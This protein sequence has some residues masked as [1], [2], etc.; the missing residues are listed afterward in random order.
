[1]L[2]LT[3]IVAKPRVATEYDG[4]ADR[5]EEMYRRKAERAAS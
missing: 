4:R 1:M 2:A 5:D 3:L